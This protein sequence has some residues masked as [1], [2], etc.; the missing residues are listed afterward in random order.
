MVKKKMKVPASLET[1]EHYPMGYSLHCSN[2]SYELLS[3]K[4][5]KLSSVVRLTTFFS[6]QVA[7][8]KIFVAAT[9]KLTVATT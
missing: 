9:A 7:S 4:E 5:L 1:T 6:S 3:L 2:P 8:A